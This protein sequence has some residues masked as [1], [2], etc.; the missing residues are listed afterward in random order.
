MRAITVAPGVPHSARLD[1]VPEPAAVP[2]TLLVRALALGVC[3]TDREILE[4]LYGDAPPGE[5][6][7]ILGHES[8]GEVEEAPGD[9]DFKR[10]DRVVGIV[11]RPDPV[12]CPACA[13]GE[14]DMC[15]NGRYTERGIKALHGFGSER[16][17]LEP[18][19]AVKIDPA[20]GLAGVLLEPA[21]IV[22]KAWDHVARIGQRSRSWVP[23]TLLVTGAGP[24]GLLA[25]MMGVQRKLDV[26]VYDHNIDGPKAQ[27]VGDLGAHYISDA[28]TIDALSFDV[29]MECTAVPA[30]IVRAMARAAPSG[31]VCLLGVSSAGKSEFDIGGFNRKVVLNNDV[32]FGSVNANLSHYQ[33]AAQ[34]LARA[35]RGWLDRLISRKVPLAR[36]QEALQH[37]PDDIKVVIDFGG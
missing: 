24:I 36:W 25:A 32:V 26:T 2:G 12:P 19:F 6:R 10:G 28:M 27:L 14:W 35:D 18:Q 4:G 3:G 29:V 13:A 17:R 22:A 1:E 34:T 33:S 21:S 11:R 9:S 37:R 23:R 20:L 8:L 31:I 5:P 15:R 30:V 7:L 16:F